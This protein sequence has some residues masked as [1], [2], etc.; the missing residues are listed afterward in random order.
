MQE[1]RK[2]AREGPFSQISAVASACNAN[3][4]CC[5]D[6]FLECPRIISV[7]T[8]VGGGLCGLELLTCLE[9]GNYM[10]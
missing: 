3:G 5:N 9:E 4:C 8:G 6:A 10:V 2:E 7:S 1:E